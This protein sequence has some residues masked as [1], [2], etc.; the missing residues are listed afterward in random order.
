MSTPVHQ[1]P[2]PVWPAWY[3]PVAFGAGLMGTVLIGGVALGI[4]AAVA[5]VS[6]PDDSPTFIILGTLIQ[7]A[8]FLGTAVAFAAMAGRPRPWQFGLRRTRLWPAVG[9]A[10]LGLFCF[11]VFS[12]VYT[13]L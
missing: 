8:V 1:E 11:F 5:N 3:A 12:Y 2:A 10:A 13:E 6:K 4:A 9:W 7:S